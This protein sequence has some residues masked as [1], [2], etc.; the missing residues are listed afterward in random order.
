MALQEKDPKDTSWTVQ[1]TDGN[2]TIDALYCYD[3]NITQ[4]LKSIAP[5]GAQAI[6]DDLFWAVLAAPVQLNPV[7]SAVLQLVASASF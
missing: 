7:G 3:P 2:D 6:D 1:P 4:S 5:C